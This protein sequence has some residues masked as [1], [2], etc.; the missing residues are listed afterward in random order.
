[1]YSAA[2]EGHE[3]RLTWQ[4]PWHLNARLEQMECNENHT[5]RVEVSMF[6]YA[7]TSNML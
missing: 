6:T 5:L 3:S 4:Q 2:A 7:F 1:M